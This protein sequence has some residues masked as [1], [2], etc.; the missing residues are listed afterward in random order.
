MKNHH[1]LTLLLSLAV[2]GL[3]I[4]ACAPAV[5]TAETPAIATPLTLEEPSQLDQDRFSFEG[6]SFVLDPTL[7]AGASGEVVPEN[8]GSQDGPYWDIHPRYLT[9]SFS[10]YPTTQNLLK[11]VIAVYPVQAYRDLTPQAAERIDALQDLLR[12][13]PADSDQIPFLPVMNAGQVFRSNI[14]YL[15][16]KNGNGVRFLAIYAQY[17]APVNNQDLIYAFQGLTTDGEYLVSI[18]LPINHPDLPANMNALAISELEAIAQDYEGYR[19]KMADLL[20]DLPPASFIPDLDRL[21]ALVTS[22]RIDQ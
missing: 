21:D 18:I 12:Q 16:F 17:A 10:G 15:D 4:S 13:Q 8:P 11:P 1:I 6:F 2:L 22:L 5:T 20:A 14:E 3:L 19:A 7:A 9:I